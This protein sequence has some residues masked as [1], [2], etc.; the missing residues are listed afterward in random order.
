VLLGL[1]GYDVPKSFEWLQTLN[2]FGGIP[3][4]VGVE[5]LLSS[6]GL[7]EGSQQ[8][9]IEGLIGSG[10]IFPHQSDGKLEVLIKECIASLLGL[11]GQHM[12]DLVQNNLSQLG[13]RAGS[14]DNYL[15]SGL[16]NEDPV[17][18]LD[19]P[20]LLPNLLL[21]MLAYHK[22]RFDHLKL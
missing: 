16:L 13:A 21:L 6:F 14:L 19:S 10:E 22:L 12:I 20:P 9:I 4:L 17:D 18:L 15:E 8:E 7:D 1:D 5:R 3:V 11:S 2:H